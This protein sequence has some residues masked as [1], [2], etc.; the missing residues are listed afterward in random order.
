MIEIAFGGT[1]MM[2]LA[3]RN[4]KA[5]IISIFKEIKITM[6]K[7]LKKAWEQCLIKQWTSEKGWKLLKK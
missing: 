6:L 4:V 3:D 2:H 7:E 1:Q 5:T